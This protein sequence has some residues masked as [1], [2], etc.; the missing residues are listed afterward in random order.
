MQA[1]AEREFQIKSC[2][3]CDG[4]LPTLVVGGDGPVRE[5]ECRNCGATYLAS[6]SP[7]SPDQLRDTVKLS[8][9]F[10][11]HRDAATT[12]KV[13]DLERELRRHPRKPLMMS[14]P[15]TKLDHDLFPVGDEFAVVTR[16]LSASGIAIVHSQSLVGKL[17]VLVEL[18]DIGHVQL[19]L[20]IVRCKKVGS[21]YEMGGAFFDRR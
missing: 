10:P 2:V 13:K 5:W 6:L 14:V 11:A 16:N 8:H 7:T 15:A 12:L 4:P 19:L 18:P 20:R 21:L 9:Y 17:A 3:K 1:V